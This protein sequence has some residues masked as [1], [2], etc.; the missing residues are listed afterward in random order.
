MQDSLGALL[1]IG[2]IWLVFRFAFGSSSSSSS[3]A[4]R[5][6]AAIG[7]AAPAPAQSIALRER[8]NNVPAEM[9]QT[10]QTMFPHVSAEAIRYDLVRSGNV[11]VTCE[12]ILND[13]GLPEPPT[14]LFG[15]ARPPP[16]TRPAESART[17]S[18]VLKG[19][20]S[21]SLIARFGLESRLGAADAAVGHEMGI[22]K[23]KG[24]QVDA[25]IDPTPQS[26]KKAWSDDADIRTKELRRRKEQMILNARRRMEA[27][28]AQKSSP[29]A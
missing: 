16:Q 4:G 8:V 11:E 23:G 21:S 19:T 15:P 18:G 5:G 27:A 7:G 28:A 12:K 17:T 25:L 3:G 6:Q 24:K 9:V 2:L 1:A 14:G 10:V 29:S 26:V 20:G 13:G 22:G